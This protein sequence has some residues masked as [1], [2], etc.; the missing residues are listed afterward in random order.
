M[1]INDAEATR[2]FV[3]AHMDRTGEFRHFLTT[4]ERCIVNDCGDCSDAGQTRMASVIRYLCNSK[5]PRY[6]HIL[7]RIHRKTSK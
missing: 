5:S 2:E 7:N 3:G 4:R 1:K 6:F